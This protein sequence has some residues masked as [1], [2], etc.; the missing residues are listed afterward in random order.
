MSYIYAPLIGLII[1]LINLLAPV[2]ALLALP[3]IRWD[4]VPT[5]QPQRT[6]I[7]V[8]TI[9]G[10]LPMWLRWLQTPDQRFP[11]DLAILEVGNLFARRGKWVTAWVWMGLRNPLMGLA[12]WLGK[13]T[14]NYAPE[15]VIGLWERTDKFGRIWLYTLAIGSVHLITGYTVYALL[16]GSFRAAPVFTLKRR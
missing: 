7:P 11:G 2:L 15:G 16:D 5:T 3:F 10:D 9:M 12:A 8:T 4:D 6:G 1:M 14:S 13:P